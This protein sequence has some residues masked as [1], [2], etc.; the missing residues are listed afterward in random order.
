MNTIRIKRVATNFTMVP[1]E[2]LNDPKL[3][4]AAKGVLAY[5]IGKPS[6]W[7]IRMADLKKVGG[8]GDFAIRGIMR[9]LAEAGY[10]K[11]ETMRT[12]RGVCGTRWVVSDLASSEPESQNNL[13]VREAKSQE[14][15]P[16]SNTDLFTK[17]DTPLPPRGGEVAFPSSLDTSQFRAA[18]SDWCVHRRQIRAT[19]TPLT[20]KRQLSLL[21]SLGEKGAIACI[22]K[23]ISMGWTGLFPEKG[24]LVTKPSEHHIWRNGKWVDR[25]RIGPNI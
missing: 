25:R 11:L 1:N 7:V 4:W 15:A 13:E 22:N 2:I 8:C 16:L 23:A 9:E 21:E 5:L 24:E 6:D 18:W 3:S 10:A 14:T 19:L 17:K 12:E 20:I